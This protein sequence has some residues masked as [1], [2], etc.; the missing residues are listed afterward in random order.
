MKVAR[1]VWQLNDEDYKEIE[2]L[3]EK[4]IALENLSKIIDP[5]NNDLYEKMIKDY[6]STV[7]TFDN[8]WNIMKEKHQWTAINMWLDFQ[9]KKIMTYDEV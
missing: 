4:K 3:F 8:W 9:T 2:D 7:R 6:G 5:S 1:E